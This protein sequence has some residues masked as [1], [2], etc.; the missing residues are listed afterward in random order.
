MIVLTLRRV[1]SSSAFS[2]RSA[3]R[4]RSQTGCTAARC[5]DCS[6][7][8]FFAGAPPEGEA[9]LALL[10]ASFGLRRMPVA[11]AAAGLDEWSFPPPVEPVRRGMA[12]GADETAPVTSADFGGWLPSIADLSCGPPGDCKMPKQ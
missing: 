2:A 6:G 8:S 4:S 1:S 7:A 5:G 9:E 10:L 11:T 12:L 3:A